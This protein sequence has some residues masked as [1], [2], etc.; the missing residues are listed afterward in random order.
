M[1]KTLFFALSAACMAFAPHAAAQTA[2]KRVYVPIDLRQ[3]HMESDTAQW[4]WSRCRQ[5]PDLAIFWQKGFGKD[6][7]V[8]PP[9][10]GHNMHFDLSNLERRLERFYHFYRDTLHF[11]LPG[12]KADRYKMMVMVNYNLDGTAY[13]G[14]YDNFI[15]ALWVAPNRIQDHKLNALAHELGHSFQMQVAA[16]SISD[17]W[18]GSPFFEMTSQ[19]MLWQVNPDWLT[20]ENYHYEAFKKQFNKAFLSIDNIYHS[21][22]VLEYWA[23]KRGLGCIADLYR[24]GQKGEDPVMTYKR[25]Y[26]LSQSA[27]CDEMMDYCQHMVNLDF[28]HARGETRRYACQLVTPMRRLHP[29]DPRWVCPDS[30]AVPQDYGFNVIRLS[31]AHPG[32]RVSARVVA[33]KESTKQPGVC[34]SWRYGFVAVTASGRSVYGA[35]VSQGRAVL[36]L[37]REPLR[38]VALVVM[39]APREHVMLFEQAVTRTYP[40]SVK[41]RGCEAE[42]PAVR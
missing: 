26:H 41:L 40:Y 9:L 2:D 7:A 11:T 8:A 36:V 34:A 29:K 3:C 31:G 38:E 33:G 24:H 15:G 4:A 35:P 23:E 25:L 39:G 21:P 28:S 13:G 27:F 5:T 22:Y 17:T 30:T 14:T 20:D 1:K 19:W 37:P 10:N 42:T 18:G 6:P 32:A 16:D 12:S